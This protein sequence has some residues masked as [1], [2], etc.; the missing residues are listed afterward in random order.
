M[1]RRTVRLGLAG[2]ALL[3]ALSVAIA[4]GLAGASAGAR[5]PER[6]LTLVARDMG[7]YLPNGDQ[8]NPTLRLAPGERVKVRLVNQEAGILHDLLVESLGFDIPAFREAGERVAWLE[9]PAEPGRYEY[10]CSLHRRMMR[11]VIEVGD[12]GRETATR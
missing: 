10:V 1:S 7:F 4:A 5:P 8:P 2:T 6:E 9:A 12:G 3:V 11:G